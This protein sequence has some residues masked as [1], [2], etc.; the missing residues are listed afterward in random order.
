MKRAIAASIS[1]TQ[2]DRIIGGRLIQK[3]KIVGFS[4]SSYVIRSGM[5]CRV[6]PHLTSLEGFFPHVS[7]AHSS[8]DCF[9]ISNPPS[10]FLF[11]MIYFFP[12]FFSYLFA[13]KRYLS[14]ICLFREFFV[15]NKTNFSSF[16]VL[17][18]NDILFLYL[19]RK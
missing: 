6:P 18:G 9:L 17:L 14:F 4:S 8:L 13:C 19:G 7:P 11:Q 2:V 5:I 16:V 3:Q 10:Y 12:D 15:H 1:T